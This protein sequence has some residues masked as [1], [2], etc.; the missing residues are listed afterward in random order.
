M[1]KPDLFDYGVAIIGM[2]GRFPGASTL[3]QF[4]QNLSGG[5]ESIARFSEAELDA[6]GVSPAQRVDPSF[7]PAGGLLSDIDRFDAAFFDMPPREAELT[8]PQHRLFLECAWEALERSGYSA[9]PAA[10]RIAVYAGEKLNSYLLHHLLAHPQ[11]HAAFA[12]IQATLSNDRDFL[13]TL[14]SYKLHLTGPSMTVQTACS[15]SLVAVHLACQSLLNGESDLALAGGVAIQVPQTTGYHYQDGSIL[16]P[17]GHCRAFDAQAQ[18]TVGGNGVG[19]V[20][21]KRLADAITSRDQIYAVIR[22]S[23]I[24]NDG[25]QK[26]G[27]TAPSVHGQA[28][29]IRDALALADVTP[30]TIDYVEAHGT[31]TPLGDPIEVKALA[32]AF[33]ARSGTGPRCA[34]GSVKTNIGHLDAAAGV[35]GLIKTAL[36]L[37]H[38]QLPPSLHFQQPNPQIDFAATPF[39]VS[40]ALTDWTRGDHPRRA[41][42]SSFGMGG[43]N[44]HVILEEAPPVEESGPSRPVQLLL[45]SA[46]TETALDAA[47]AN[48]RTWLKATPYVN[49][50][51]V[52]YTLQVGRRSF[53]HRR[54]VVCRDRAEAIAGLESPPAGADTAQVDGDGSP[55]VIWLFPGQGSQYVGMGHDLYRTEARF[56]ACVDRCAGLFEPHL[57]LDL[58]AVLY[59][60]D[61]QRAEAASLLSQTRIAQPALFVVSYALAQLW[62]DWGVRPAAM[63]GHSLGEYVAACLAGV[64]SLEDSVALIATRGRL[65]QQLPAGAMLVVALDEDAVQP[66][67]NEHLSL[68]AINSP[69]Q[70]V[71]SGQ[72]AAIEALR[73]RLTEHGVRC[74]P[75]STSHAFHSPMVEPICAVFAEYVRQIPRSVPRI[76]FISNVTGTWITEHEA[77]DPDYWA[78]HLRAPVRFGA[79]VQE[80]VRRPKPVLLE[81]GP[82]RALRNLARQAAPAACTIFSSLPHADE[83]QP[84]SVLLMQTLGHLWLADVAID[85]AAGYAHERRQLVAL[86]TY[87]F[88]RRRYWLEAPAD[89][90]DA[91]TVATDQRL[92]PDQW[93]YIPV[94]KQAQPTLAQASNADHPACWL[95]FADE[96]G[97]AA[98][99]VQRL[100]QLGHNPITVVCGQRFAQTGARTYMLDPTEPEQ[101]AA[102][103]DHLA[104]R[105]LTPTST[106]HL[107]SLTSSDD[108]EP[109]DAP[110]F[111]RA[112]ARGFYSLLF[113]AR[114]LG[115]RK[116][117]ARIEIVSNQSQPVTGTEALAAEKATALGLS[118]IIP[119]EYP[120]IACRHIDIA[121]P[122]PNT[123]QEARLLDA[124]I[125]EMQQPATYP[126]VAYRGQQRWVQ[127]Y[128]PIQPGSDLAH[129]SILRPHGVYLIT[130]GLG[131]I[132]LVL[133]EYLAQTVQAK[134]IL[135]SRS[136][137]AAH[138]QTPQVQRLKAL[139]AEVLI[140]GADV[141]DQEQM[142]AIIERIEAQ[143]GALH[144]VIHAAGIVGERAMRLIEQTDRRVGEEQFQPKV[145]GLL[146]LERVLRGRDLDFCLVTSSLSSILGGLGFAAYAAANAFM[147]LF[148]HQQRQISPARW[149]SVNWD[150]WQFGDESIHA[151]HP[152]APLAEAGIRPQ[153]GMETLQRVLASG[154]LPQIAVSVRDLPRRIKQAS[155]RSGRGSSGGQQPSSFES[156]YARPALATGYAAP[157]SAVERTI[158]ELWQALLGIDQVGIHDNFFALGGD[159]LIGF[160]V[161]AKAAQAGL[162]ITARQVLE[163][164]TIA[165]LARVACPSATTVEQDLVIGPMPFIQ[166]WFFEQNFAHPQHWNVAVLLIP[167]RRLD[168][169]LVQRVLRQL[170]LHH[171]ALR[172]RF[173]VAAPYWQPYIAAP[174]EAVPLTVIDLST[175]AEVEHHA[176]IEETAA[177]LH[178]TLDL[179]DGPMIR[180]ALFEL[181]PDRPQRLQV[182]MHHLVGDGISMQIVLEDFYT[183]YH[184]LLRDEAIAL[185]A[186]TT[187]F[188]HWSERLVAYAQSP[189]LRREL[190][191]YWLALPWERATPL[192]VDYP[193]GRSANTEA[194]TQSVVVSLTAEETHIL[195]KELLPGCD[196]RIRDVLVA[197]MVGAITRWSGVPG[198]VVDLLGHGRSTIFDDIDLSRTVGWI[199]NGTRALLSVSPADTPE[200][201]VRAI[202]EQL[203][204][205]P[206]RGFGYDVLRYV[207]DDPEI[208]DAMRTLPPTEALFNYLGNIDQARVEDQPYRPAPESSGP[209]HDPHNHRHLLFEVVGHIFEQQLHVSWT[210]SVNLHRRS[211]V[212]RLARYFVDI[213]R[214]LLSDGS[215]DRLL[216]ADGDSIAMPEAIPATR[217]GRL[218]PADDAPR[219]SD[220]AASFTCGK[221]IDPALMQRAAQGIVT[222]P[223][224]LMPRQHWFFEDWWRVQVPQHYFIPTLLELESAVDAALLEQALSHLLLHH[225]AL[226]MRF[227][228]TASGWRQY[229]AGVDEA[230]PFSTIDLSTI[231][232]EEQ[233]AAFQA[234]ISEIE[235]S[236][237][238]SN[239][240]L[241]RL[242]LFDLGPVTPQRLLLMIHHLVTDAHSQRIVLEDLQTAYLHLS[243]GMPVRLPA[244]TTSLQQWAER[245][246]EYAH[247]EALRHEAAYWLGLPWSEVSRLLPELPPVETERWIERRVSLGGA[248]TDRLLAGARSG[249]LQV[250]DLLL[251]ALTLAFMQWTDVR[252]LLVDVTH[253]GRE[254]IFDDLD[255]S[256]TV[257]WFTTHTPRL[258][259]LRDARDL[260]H[261][262]RLVK[263]QGRLNPHRGFDHNV[264]HHLNTDPDIS[265][266]LRALPQPEIIFLY[267]GRIMSG[268]GYRRFSKRSLIRSFLPFPGAGTGKQNIVPRVLHVSAHIG[269]G[270]LQCG[271]LYMERVAIIEQVAQSFLQVLAD[272]VRHLS[273][274]E[275]R[276]TDDHGFRSGDDALLDLQ[277]AA[278]AQQ[279][280]LAAATAIDAEQR[281]HA[282]AEEIPVTRRGWLENNFDSP[283]HWNVAA[284]FTVN[285]LIDPALMRRAVQHVM[286]HHD[287]LRLRFHNTPQ[288][289]RAFIAPPGDLPFSVVDLSDVADAARGQAIT[290]AATELQRSLDLQHGPVLRVAAFVCGSTA[291]GRLLIIVHHLAADGISFQILLHDLERAY[292]QLRRGETIALPAQTASFKAWSER[293]VDYVRSPALTQQ[294][295]YW[296]GRPWTEVRRLPVDFPEGQSANIE[297][298]TRT[299]RTSLSIQETQ[300]LLQTVAA[301]YN[302]QIRELVLTGI[303][304][305]L[306]DWTEHPVHLICVQ[307]HGR[308]IGL[309]SID[310]SRTVG[311]LATATRLVLDLRGVTTAAS[312][313][314][315][316]QRQW[317]AI[318][319]HG[320][321]YDWLLNLSDDAIKRQ[322]RALPP[323]EIVLNYLGRI[324]QSMSMSSSFGLA[325]ES[326]GPTRST[327][328]QRPW[329]FEVIGSIQGKQ[330]HLDWCYCPSLHRAS[331]VERLAKSCL[332]AM[333]RLIEQADATEHQIV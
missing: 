225:D 102:L 134:L 329:L 85:W 155:R 128:E 276:S 203:G 186:K 296:L 40:T 284:C 64:F 243:Q 230:V 214:S 49:L 300:A 239:G 256:R 133:A 202:K 221:P 9:A 198:V 268:E 321:G 48:L 308:Q 231:R 169:A 302:V 137:G 330:L 319:N 44:A 149:I 299:L 193:E 324:D 95:V 101:Y 165:E 83:Q 29:A 104:A 236:L 16:S 208:L 244:K 89:A 251:A 8:D 237:D 17:D 233:E 113:L 34:L 45:L 152:D 86:P 306:A 142:Q 74:R 39:R 285:E 200:Q 66:L 1:N 130:G 311:W 242:I 153:E 265:T 43:T 298:A 204:R 171:D 281:V 287:A 73:Q 76:P 222:G 180:V 71:I 232:Q 163:H 112:Q 255:I 75:V 140:L 107:W 331:T 59:P 55:E 301:S 41:G 120:D 67:L 333:R 53:A 315:T 147:D 167:P 138:E 279:A 179:C 151:D 78:R 176:V 7:V 290:A 127:V 24:N 150:G 245:L 110:S 123:W 263:E 292:Q 52:A 33:G 326:Y 312:A 157:R 235:V 254:A 160:Q 313:L 90:E 141:A 278:P 247:S 94:W 327:Q 215:R 172:L 11:R 289:W 21:L 328:C 103:L 262:V 318:P 212:E 144:G 226:R 54:I 58:R 22:G 115:T 14:V 88:E 224:P 30:D 303:G 258:F 248:E 178:T 63:L 196:A 10:T 97:V 320:W 183:A 283:H 240:P 79:G 105:D 220:A 56:R 87:P 286:A 119:Q 253:Y 70:C 229:I 252:V 210:Y 271:L 126:V 129:P 174:D 188:K 261:A 325:P 197:A 106:V 280:V 191:E 217:R 307:G 293:V 82:G 205:I 249:D 42:V 25:G 19:V 267:H 5:V 310:L 181:G 15:T 184:Q 18:G 111:K 259:D 162:H 135:V 145:Y 291:P 305:A 332:D 100:E 309:D 31:G 227:E 143:Y 170:L 158:A 250:E 273:P 173:K 125:G 182:I 234:A 37:Q 38:R 317:R 294:V 223:V 121:L 168:P 297:G 84:D 122:Q 62:L 131:A 175:R 6:A 190:E 61:D 68:A 20:V 199:A 3:E 187:S 132:G 77:Q 118:K 80:I 282:V 13:S 35:A 4:W 272:I 124:L 192:P 50:A 36:M 275:Q 116:L 93:L 189:A 314:E 209:A 108:A 27:F 304:L 114:A 72:T 288:G 270:Q 161:V 213:I 195:L 218:E 57:G 207:S 269:E 154:G 159:S 156:R 2:A 32:L 166:R 91:P 12:N 65:M 139:G 323:A 260:G 136:A 146:T 322:M 69:T 264:L 26:V 241:I 98:R 246:T 96:L 295:P 228:R 216:A 201:M 206:N 316:T 219:P 274:L 23:A 194:S 28:Q 109:L 148:V 238:L 46:K 164:Q 117:A 266:R 92:A 51:D 277:H 177:H 257:G 185:P 211:T 81:V 60:Q 47:T 99:L